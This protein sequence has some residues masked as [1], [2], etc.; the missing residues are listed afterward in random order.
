MQWQVGSAC[1]QD[2]SARTKTLECAGRAGRAWQGDCTL[3]AS[4]ASEA[5]SRSHTCFPL[6][7]TLS[8]GERERRCARVRRLRGR[9]FVERWEMVLPLPKG[10]GWGEGKSVSDLPCGRNCKNAC[11]CGLF[12]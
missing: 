1:P 4:G 6:T 9:W 7:P 11:R 12:C 3:H 2:G 8:L 5:N 10:E